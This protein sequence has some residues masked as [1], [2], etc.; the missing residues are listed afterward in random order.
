MEARP[1][2]VKATGQLLEGSGP[3]SDGHRLALGNHDH[4]SASTQTGKP[5]F[6][7]SNLT[8][9]SK[10][11]TLASNLKIKSHILNQTPSAYVESQFSRAN[12]L[13][14]QPRL[15]LEMCNVQLLVVQHLVLP[16]ASHDKIDECRQEGV[17]HN[18]DDREIHC[19]SFPTLR[20][21]EVQAAGHIGIPIEPKKDDF[22]NA[23]PVLAFRRSFFF[24]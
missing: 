16:N 7:I 5:G 6:Q 15:R 2:S 4:W 10:T 14:S 9:R 17:A 3:E 24:E 8:F 18:K 20:L 11:Q 22:R 13:I 1:H 12:A 21:R 23:K 19:D